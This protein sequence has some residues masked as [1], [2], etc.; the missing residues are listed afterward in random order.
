[1]RMT[2][3]Q[4]IVDPLHALVAGGLVSGTKRPV[5]LVA[6]RFNVDL[7][8]GLA[9]VS[10]TR[11]FKNAEETSIEA[12]ITFPVPV[13]AV[14]FS[15]TA[16]IAGR[17][18]KARAQRKS[19]ARDDYEDAIE[20]GKTAVLHEEVLRGVHMLSIGHLPPGVEVEVSATWTMTLTNLNGRGYMRI[21]LTVGDIYGRSGLPDSDDLTYGGPVQTAELTVQCRDG[22]VILLGGRLDNGRAQVPLNAPIDLEVNGWTPADLCGRAADG[23]EVVL[24]VEP[25]SVGDADVDVA[26]VIDHSESMG[27]ICSADNRNLTKHQA[28]LAGLLTIAA[29]IKQPDVIDLWEFDNAHRHVG[30][31]RGGNSLQSLMG[32]LSGPA[33]GTEIGA[34]LAGV[35]A[36]SRGRDVLLVT[37][38]KSHALDVQ[39]LARTGRRFSVVLVGEDSLEANVG[40]LAALTGGEIFV[41]AGADLAEVLNA[42]LLSLRTKHRPVSPI[43]GRPQHISVRRAGMTLT[44]AWKEVKASIEETAER[45]A[46]AALAAIVALPALDTESAARL[47]ETEGLVTHLTSLVL[48]DEVGAAQDGI[49]AT[50]KVA[51]PAPRLSAMQSV[52]SM[53]FMEDRAEMLSLLPSRKSA[54]PRSSLHSNLLPSSIDSELRHVELSSVGA[55]I[56]WDLAPHLLQAGDLS[57][58][59]RDVARAIQTAAALTEVVVL[60][61]QLALDPVALV[62]GLI[63]RSE[64]SRSRSATRLAK[65]IFGDIASA[66]L[67]HI[68]QILCLA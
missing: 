52:A 27:E 60:A 33:G 4:I 8:H 28:V 29:R 35:A 56:D 34:A 61:R 1:M 49:P 21:P 50:R 17:V 30:S 36:Q 22:Q 67:D 57:T 2:A 46:V 25:T 6:A 37:D 41:S 14:L 38:G 44:A 26:L 62:I 43:T 32:R 55:K 24:R 58:L 31:A 20:R 5:P 53:H 3:P 64:S 12:T 68:A 16:R 9:T 10:A 51:L 40:Y 11:I 63:A 47:A 42:A 65:A 54:L 13:H 59:D 39:A 23:R 66:R 45:R 48:V 19:Q 18:L 15:L 7:N